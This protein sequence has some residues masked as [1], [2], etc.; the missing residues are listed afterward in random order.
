LEA[1]DRLPP[2]L[3][4]RD[5]NVPYKTIIGP[6]LKARTL[7]NQKAEAAVAVRCVNR[8]TALGMPKSLRIA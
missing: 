2:P 3:A 6:G 7:D 5:R 8:F 4:R 1:G